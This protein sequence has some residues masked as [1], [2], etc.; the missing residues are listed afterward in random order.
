MDE[1]KYYIDRDGLIALV[2]NIS[3][4]IVQHTSGEI[5]FTEETNPNT[6]DTIK[7]VDNPNNFPTVKAVTDYVENIDFKTINGESIVGEGDIQVN[8]ETPPLADENTDGLM[9]KENYT[10]LNN[11]KEDVNT[12][13]EN[14]GTI[15]E[16][17][18]DIKQDLDTIKET[19][20][21]SIEGNLNNILQ[22]LNDDENTERIQEIIDKYN[23]IQ[24]FIDGLGD[25]NETLSG[26]IEDIQSLQSDVESLQDDLTELR[27]IV[28][29]IEG[30][31]DSELWEAVN[32]SQESLQNLQQSISSLQHD[33]NELNQEVSFLQGDVRNINQNIE[34]LDQR[35]TNL[36]QNPVVPDNL[37]NHVVLTQHEYDNLQEYDEDTL[38]LI[39]EDE[40][41][42]FGDKF[43]VILT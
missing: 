25:D 1:N 19:T 23:Q 38:Y 24:E 36:E 10:D 18:G 31:D 9:S 12:I 34:G 41:W 21:P 32:S 4:S 28:E 37:L 30:Y 43:P 11:I 2:Q 16:D 14:I 27:E 22:L 3:N 20:L 15:N 8:T 35:I 33:V 40:G 6:E 26:I 13:N 17:I 39:L 42:G 5:T 7:S 29:G